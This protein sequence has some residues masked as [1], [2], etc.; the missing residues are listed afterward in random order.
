MRIDVVTL[1]P[2]KLD[3]TTGVALVQASQPV[4]GD[5]DAEPFADAP[6]LM[7]LGL[8]AVPYPPSA[9]GH[10]EGLLAGGVGGLN[11]CVIG[12][13]DVRT[14]SIAGNLKP[15][16][17]VL[18]TTGPN[19]AAQ[20]QLKEDKRQAVLVAKKANGEQMLVSLDGNAE[21]MTIAINGAVIA[22]DTD[23]T[24]SLIHPNGKSG[25]IIGEAGVQVV[26]KLLGGVPVPGTSLAMGT[27]A[28]IGAA[29][30]IPCLSIAGQ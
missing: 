23:G 20:L 14:A 15:G 9:G 18:S 19:Q 10:C 8:H 5:D 30:L 25:L 29:G 12:A 16:D 6:M 2:G 13:R 17:T 11:G 22:V 3:E 26:G 28:Q 7:A 4:S 1:S 24:I 21:T 27:A